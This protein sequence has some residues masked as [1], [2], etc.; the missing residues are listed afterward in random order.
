MVTVVATWF[1]KKKGFAIGIVAS[2]ASIAGLIYPMMIKFL[3][4]EVGFNNAQRY[5][6]T[7]TAI[8]C[9]FAILIARP[10]PAHPFR[11]PETWARI[12]VWVDTHAFR[13]HSFAWLCAAIS[14]LFFGFYASRTTPREVDLSGTKTRSP[15]P[16]V[17]SGSLAS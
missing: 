12:N 5:T 1:R 10:N 2:G 4:Q 9:L 13:N 16:C 7:L 11:K 17:H 3:I 15:M 6:A 8:T 14:F